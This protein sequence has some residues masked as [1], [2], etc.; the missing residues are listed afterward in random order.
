MLVPGTVLIACFSFAS[1]EGLFVDPWKS[2]KDGMFGPKVGLLAE[3]GFGD[4]VVP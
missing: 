3:S 1:D 4:G 2:L